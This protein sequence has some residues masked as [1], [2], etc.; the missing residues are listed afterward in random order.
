M[1][2]HRRNHKTTQRERK[3]CFH[4]TMYALRTGVDRLCVWEDKSQ[5]LLLRCERIQRRHFGMKLLAYALMH[6]RC[7]YT[8][9]DTRRQETSRIVRGVCDAATHACSRY[10]CA[11]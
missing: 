9:R 7:G 8:L 2:E 11:R 5:W 3:R 1:K 6:L 4:T 10:L